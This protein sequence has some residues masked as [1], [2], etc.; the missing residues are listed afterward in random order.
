MDHTKRQCILIS[1][2]LT[3]ESELAV[4]L[5]MEHFAINT[6]DPVAMAKWYCEHLGM[7]VARQGA[8]PHHMHFLADASGRVVMEIYCN[9]P[10]LVPDYRNQNPLVLHLAFVSSDIEGTRERLIAAGAVAEGEPF[11]T[12]D[13]DHI[14]MLRDPWGFCIQFCKRAVPMV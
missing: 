1:E 11:F 6:A 13:G 8:P 12:P 10:E 2:T 9:P 7:S 4:E 5:Q 3:K 14:A